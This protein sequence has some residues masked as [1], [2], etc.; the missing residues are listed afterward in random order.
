MREAGLFI[1]HKGLCTA[2]HSDSSF[3]LCLNELCTQQTQFIILTVGCSVSASLRILV[4]W[5]FVY[6]WATESESESRWVI[7]DSLRPH[8]IVHGILQARILE[9][10]AIPVSRDLPYPGIEPRS[11]TLQV[12]SL[13]PESPEKPKNT[14]VGSPSLL[15]GIFQTQESNWGLLHCRWRE[16]P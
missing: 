16:K 14:G 11:P 8:G 13:P 15:Q 2:S 6:V 4:K 5:G 7:S 10:V 9:W 12:D 1:L 3:F